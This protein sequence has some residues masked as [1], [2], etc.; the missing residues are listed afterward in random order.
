MFSLI[1]MRMFSREKPEH[2]WAELVG[3]T[4]HVSTCERSQK[5][6]RKDKSP[7]IKVGSPNRVLVVGKTLQAIEQSLKDAELFHPRVPS[8]RG[9]I[10]T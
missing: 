6:G 8:F 9:V 10:W 5:K 2:N 3:I 4:R 7:V 1:F